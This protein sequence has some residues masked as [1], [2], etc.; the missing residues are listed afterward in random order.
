MPAWVVPAITTAV[1]AISAARNKPQRFDAK[2]AR[3]INDRY[4]GARPSGYLTAEDSAAVDRRRARGVSSARRS[5][6]LARE[7][8]QRQISG[9]RL[10]GA[11]AAALFSDANM[12]EAAGREA[13]VTGASDLEYGLF[14][15]NRDFER[16]KLFK[17]W[18]AELGAASGSAQQDA[19]RE[20]G[21]WNSILGAAP[22]I[23]GAWG[24][25][26]TGPSPSYLQ[27]YAEGGGG[28]YNPSV[29]PRG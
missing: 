28:Y 21:L 6:A 29:R 24:S 8:A 20:A 11:S 27:A 10:S 9:R 23:A 16:E 12:A 4:M 26:P 19:Q 7:S 25:M 15:A 1:G 22:V 18:G 5:G 14:G 2:A 13:A 17:S 3:R